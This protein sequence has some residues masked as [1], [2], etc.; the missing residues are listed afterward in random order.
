LSEPA[1]T[2]GFRLDRILV[3]EAI[4]LIE[5][6][7][8]VQRVRRLV[9]RVINFG[10]IARLS[11]VQST[12]LYSFAEPHPTAHLLPTRKPRPRAPA[13]LIAAL[14]RFRFEPSPPHDRETI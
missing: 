7:G 1:F 9:R 12:S 10:G 11:T 2:I 4:H 13:R 8:I 5:A 14:A 6:A 3:G